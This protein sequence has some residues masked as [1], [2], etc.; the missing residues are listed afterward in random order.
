MMDYDVREGAGPP[1]LSE[2]H[3]DQLGPGGHEGGR[4]PHERRQELQDAAP[5]PVPS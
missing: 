1:E 2:V 5:Q 4:E 3:R